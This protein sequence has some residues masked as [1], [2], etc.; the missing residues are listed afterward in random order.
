MECTLRD[1]PTWRSIQPL[2]PYLYL[3]AHLGYMG[4]SMGEDLPLACCPTTD[5]RRI[6]SLDTNEH[7]FLCDQDLETI[8]HIIASCSFSF[9][10][11]GTSLHILARTLQGLMETPC[12]HGGPLGADGGWATRGGE[13]T[14]YL[15][16]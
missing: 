2:T 9:R 8:D 14:P 6:H 7:C 15:H 13:L 4:T 10:Y 11:G 12:Y 16:L 1:P 3:Q 5:M